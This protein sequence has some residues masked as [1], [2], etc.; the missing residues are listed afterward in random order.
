MRLRIEFVSPDV[1][2]VSCWSCAADWD[3]V[4]SSVEASRRE[5]RSETAL[6]LDRSDL[7][8]SWMLAT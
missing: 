8:S 4:A 7:V 3:W 6:M 2:E 5:W 1:A